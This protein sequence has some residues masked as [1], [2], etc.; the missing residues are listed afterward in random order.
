MTAN[1]HNLLHLPKIVKE[2]GPLYI[3]SC[4]PFEGANGSL[5]SYIKG[6]QHVDAQI[7]ETV[8]IRQSLPYVVDHHLPCDSEASDLY[9]RM[10]A[11]RHKPNKIAIGENY[12]LGKLTNCLHLADPIHQTAL[13]KV[14]LSKTL[15]RFS[16]AI[17]DGQTMHSVEHT[18]PKKRNSHTVLYNYDSKQFHGTLLYYVTDFV[19]IYAVV[20]PFVNLLSVF[21]ADDITFCSVPHTHVYGSMS[22]SVHIILA[23]NIISLCVAM[24][25]EEISNTVYI[26]EQP[27]NIERD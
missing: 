4:F 16:R 7:L 17:I 18:Q 19:Q 12:A 10:K 14:T 21:P 11:K 27:N 5:L 3:Y 1:V 25:F 6:T 20:V 23:S 22:Q 15:G 26:C 9:Y 24:S 8:S 2:F 13:E